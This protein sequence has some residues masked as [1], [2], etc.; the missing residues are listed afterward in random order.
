MASDVLFTRPDS[1]ILQPTTLCNLDCSYCYL[2]FRRRK[3]TIS[4]E[5]ADAV[6]A[7]IRPWTENGIVEVCWHGGEPLTL[8]TARLGALMDSFAGMAVAHG[9]QTNATLITDEW[10]RFFRERDVHVGVSID[11]PA[12]DNRH[13]TDLTGKEAFARILRGIKTLARHGHEVSIIAV[14]SDPTPARARRLYEF[15]AE[16]GATWLGVNIE[17][18][19]G[20][21]TYD[22]HR[23]TAQLEEFWAAL[24]SAWTAD[25]QVRLR[26]LDRVLSYAHGFDRT[27]RTAAA[28]VDPLPTVAHDG[29]VTLISPELAGFTSPRLGDFACGNVLHTPLDTLIAKGT[30]AAWVQEYLEG[31]RRCRTSCSYFDF[32]GGGQPANRF[33]EHQRL[34]GT[35]TNYCVNSKITVLEGVLRHARNSH[36]A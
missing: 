20:V 16:L 4:R 12:E 29:T 8:G 5:V 7:S 27:R 17:E 35:R 13:R 31:L 11:G 30:R 21:N 14:V 36:A 10:C 26:E 9:I 22:N 3:L 24:A 15:A 18:Q 28:Q 33:F 34:D 1:V 19:E 32:C 6:A 2:P 23:D 25:P